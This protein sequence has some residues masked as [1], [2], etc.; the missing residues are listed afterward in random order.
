MKQVDWPENGDKVILEGNKEAKIV[1]DTRNPV[2]AADLEGGSFQVSVREQD[3]EIT[4][5][6]LI[7]VTTDNVWI[8]V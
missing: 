4:T 2:V 3:G 8:E 5:D 6:V 7:T 1:V